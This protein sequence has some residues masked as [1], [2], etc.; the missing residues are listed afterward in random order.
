MRLPPLL[1]QIVDAIS[2]DPTPTLQGLR[3]DVQELIRTMRDQ[4]SAYR[5]QEDNTQRL[6]NDLPERVIRAEREIQEYTQRENRTYQKLGLWIQLMLVMG[7]WLAFIAASIY[8]GITAYQ[9]QI[10]SGTLSEV[11]K[12][13]TTLR[14]QLVGTQAAVIDIIEKPTWLPSTKE[15]TITIKNTNPTGIIG[16]V[17]GIQ[18]LLQRRT[19][20]GEKPIGKPFVF[21]S[22]VPE[23]LLRGGEPWG[24][25]RNLPWSLPSTLSDQSKW[26]GDEYV[27]FEGNFVYDNGFGETIPNR[28]CYLWLPD[29]HLGVVGN[30]RDNGGWMGGKGSCPTVQEKITEFNGVSEHYKH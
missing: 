20:P 7:T 25:S 10:M 2:R 24:I 23:V 14:Q 17:N 9:A 22:N 18:M 26:P 29:W 27:T 13:T 11:Q 15:V 3:S 19:W 12:Q 5:K 28:F 30:S 16:K 6:Y 1:Q 4:E 8:A 21:A